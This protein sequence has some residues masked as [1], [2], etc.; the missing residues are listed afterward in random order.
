MSVFLRRSLSSSCPRF[1]HSAS[2]NITSTLRRQSLSTHN[3]APDASQALEPRKRKA[4]HSTGK[5]PL[6]KPRKPK[7]DVEPEKPRPNLLEQT[8]VQDY[9]DYVASTNNS[10]T[11]DDIER[12][13]PKIHA[14]PG[15][16]EYVED[17]KSTMESLVRSFNK[18]QLA[19]FLELYGLEPPVKRTK[20]FYAESI[21][22]HQW[23]WPSVT[24]IQKRQRDWSEVTYKSA[25]ELSSSIWMLK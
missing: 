2:Y 11:L 9:L 6:K 3:L 19:R 8:K 24:D 20:W 13:K 4:R 14:T 21:I 17:Y 5:E 1:Q 23:K 22:E 10:V 18:V 7:N 12:C 15:T 25:S 16:P